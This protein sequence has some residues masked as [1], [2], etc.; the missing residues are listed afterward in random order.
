MKNLKLH[1]K[2]LQEQ[3]DRYNAISHKYTTIF[4]YEIYPTKLPGGMSVKVTPFLE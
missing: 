3:L 4:C 1:S 2:A